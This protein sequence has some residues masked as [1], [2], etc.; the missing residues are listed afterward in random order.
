MKKIITLSLFT[1]ILTCAITAQPTTISTSKGD[2]T[3]VKKND[4]PAKKQPKKLEGTEVSPLAKEDFSFTYG[5]ETNGEWKRTPDYDIVSFSHDGNNMTAYYD[6]DA[7][8]V[9][10]MFQR[11][12]ADLP[13]ASQQYIDE[14]YPGYTKESVVYFNDNELNETNITV[15]DKQFEDDDCFYVKLKKNNQQIILKVKTSGEVTLV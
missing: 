11:K 14:G 4:T 3:P 13:S 5:T 8:L 7:K 12:F 1:M 10:T 2:K 9:G 15:F 6:A